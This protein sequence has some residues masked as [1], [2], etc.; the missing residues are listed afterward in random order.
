MSYHSFHPHNSQVSMEF[1]HYSLENRDFIV[2]KII[3]ENEEVSVFLTEETLP[4]FLQAMGLAMLKEL[5]ADTKLFLQ[6][7]NIIQ[8]TD[9]NENL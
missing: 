3:F 1:T 5:N 2:Y 9:D 4:K 8:K 6:D 7:I